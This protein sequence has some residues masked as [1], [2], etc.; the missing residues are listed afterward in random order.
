M[1]I[2]KEI[3]NDKFKFSLNLKRIR[4]NAGIKQAPLAKLCGVSIR[5]WG[6]WESMDQPTWPPAEV[7]PIIAKEINCSINDL[8]GDT[9]DWLPTTTA[10]RN[11]LSTIRNSRLPTNQIANSMIN[12]LEDMLAED[13]K[14]WTHLGARL[15]KNIKRK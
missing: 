3:S 11:L 4:R 6:A 8:Y 1:K 14:L 12:T 13:R 2:P 5:A 15:R 7:L 9:P 10:E